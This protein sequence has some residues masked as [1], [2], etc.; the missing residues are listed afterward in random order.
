M[1]QSEQLLAYIKKNGTVTPMEALIK[2]GIYR[3]AARVYDLRNA[4]HNIQT[5]I[6]ETQS[7]ARVARYWL[8]GKK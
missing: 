2:L 8:K 7:G 1:N 3:T 5:D 4:G 6:V